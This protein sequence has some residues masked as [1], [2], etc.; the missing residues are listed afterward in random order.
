M[1]AAGPLAAPVANAWEG[2]SLWARLYIG[3]AVLLTGFVLVSD[4]TPSRKL[5]GASLAAL[6]VVTYVGFDRTANRLQTTS[7]DGPLGLLFL[8]AT[9]VSG[10]ATFA[11]HP[12]YF[13]LLFGLFPLCFIGVEGWRRQAISS[14]VLGLGMG[15]SLAGWDG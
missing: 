8:G 15:V 9:L 12:L 7:T 14:V 10:I 13:V 5:A 4:T 6:S 1:S 2:T 3:S 11:V